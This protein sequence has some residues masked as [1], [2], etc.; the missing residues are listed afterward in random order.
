MTLLTSL[1]ETLDSLDPKL[2]PMAIAVF[3]GFV[4]WLYRSFWPKGWWPGP[5]E[6]W[7]SRIKAL[8]GAV[9]AAVLSGATAKDLVEFVIQTAIGALAAGGGHE[10]IQRLLKGSKEARVLEAKD[11]E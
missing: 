8:P 5:F 9:I 2:W 3:V 4:Y 7:N 6:T 10:F 1:K 11:K